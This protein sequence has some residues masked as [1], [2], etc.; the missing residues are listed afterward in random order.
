MEHYSSEALILRIKDLGESDLLVLFF[1]PENG[2]C[3]GIA[4]GGRKSRTRFVNCLDLFCLSQMDYHRKKENQLFLL[5][6]CRLLQA[7]EALRTEF[8]RLTLASYFA[9]LT[10][11]LFPLHVKAEKMFQLLVQSFELLCQGEAP[12]RVRIAF[13]AHAMAIG[14]YAIDL[15]RC[16]TC[17][18]TYKGE[19]RAV[20]VAEK[21]GISCLKCRKE[22]KAY[23]G[24][25]P[26][27][28]KILKDLQNS[29]ELRSKPLPGFSCKSIEELKRVMKEHIN[30][31]LGKKLKTKRYLD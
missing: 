27:S 31:R 20:F 13:E 29:V 3:K 30:Y 18:R 28:V 9:E 4:K 6:S 23:P 22:S 17:G 12:E 24:M 14:G 8:R 15:G 16:C 26:E 11:T 19:G 25:D 21:G 10:E 7:Y 1:T 5:D 2:L